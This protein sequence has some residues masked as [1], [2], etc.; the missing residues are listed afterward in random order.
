M[1]AICHLIHNESKMESKFILDHHSLAI[2]EAIEQQR[3]IGVHLMLRGYMTKK[4][5]MAIEA[6]ASKLQ[7]KEVQYS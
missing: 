7:L 2:K 6:S 1:E 4:W 5:Q 3:Q